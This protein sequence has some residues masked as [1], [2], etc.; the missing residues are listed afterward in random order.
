M[1]RNQN[2]VFP[3][4][5]LAAL[6]LQAEKARLLIKRRS[7][8]ENHVHLKFI[9]AKSDRAFFSLVVERDL[10]SIM[11]GASEEARTRLSQALHEADPGA[12]YS[13]ANY[14]FMSGFHP[15]G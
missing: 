5:S 7:M 4:G 13:P 9:K 14:W 15:N 11:D 10:V 3:K 8:P 2:Q 1:K 6:E 12:R